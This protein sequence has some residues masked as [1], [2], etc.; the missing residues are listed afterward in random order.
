MFKGSIVA[1]VTPFRNGKVDEKAL[2]DLIEWH[3]K[4]GTNAIVPCG[5]TG[6]SA[7][8]DYEE[9]HRV[10]RF[11]VEAVNKR[12][13]VIAGTGANATDE[14]IMITK[15]AKKSGADGALVVAPY[16][17]KPTQEGLYRHYKAVAEA[18]KMPIVLYNV[19]GRTAVNILPATVARL[20]EI[21]NIVAIKEA[22]GDMKQA[23][24][25]IRLCGNKITVLSGDD[26][27]TLPLMALGGKGTIS[28]SANVAP[29]LVS[30]M[31]ALW[32]KGRFD[33]AR[34]IHF[35]L[36]PLNAAMFI[37]TNP[38]PVKTALALMGKIREEFRLPLC[39]MAAAN[40]DKL[41]KALKDMNLI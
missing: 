13:P 30:R 4:Q 15:E 10:I 5:T 16:Y 9:H 38:I 11:T 34:K 32:E 39:E 3:I 25:V 2:G 23:S 35:Q 33:E 22:T 8:L 36:E 1:I 29:K 28:V 17:N 19:P 7:T 40:R 12:V 27:T 31:C 14:T 6:E 18:V 20:A 37:E 41:K 24:E 21:K 26:F